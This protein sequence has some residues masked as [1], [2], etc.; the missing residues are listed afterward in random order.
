[1][2]NRVGRTVDGDKTRS[3]PKICFE[4]ENK[5]FLFLARKINQL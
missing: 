2:G 3:H 1:M 4:V 5:N